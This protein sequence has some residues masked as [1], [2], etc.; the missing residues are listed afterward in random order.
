M[1]STSIHIATE[2]IAPPLITASGSAV[3]EQLSRLYGLSEKSPHVFGSPLG[4]FILRGVSYHLPRFVSFGPESAED[5]IRLALHAGF[6]GRDHRGASALATFVERLALT[7]DIG[8]GL[9]LSFFPVVN[10]SGF[11]FGIP[12]NVNAVDLATE[13]WEDSSEPE[14]AFLRHDAYARGYH[15]FIRL[16]S[17]PGEQ[18][19]GTVRSTYRPTN[20]DAALFFPPQDDAAFPVLWTSVSDPNAV[21]QG[22]LSIA[23]DYAVSPFEVVLRF[24]A[25]WNDELYRAAVGQTLHQFIGHYRAM[26]AYGLNL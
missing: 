9:N 22:P 18:I 11:A 13:N 16:E 1:I 5:S 6:D 23:D 15:G 2:R 4:P 24:P 26:F 21:R 10:P 25:T 12:R 20:R 19:V 7:P 14:I 8:R 3:H 17:G